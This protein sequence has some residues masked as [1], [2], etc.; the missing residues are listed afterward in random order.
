MAPLR[1][2]SFPDLASE[3]AS[4]NADI[5]P[6]S[7][8]P[9]G[10]GEG[11]RPDRQLNAGNLVATGMVI[12]LI[13]AVAYSIGYAIYSLLG[14]LAGHQIL[15]GPPV[16]LRLLGAA[17]VFI[18]AVV[19]ADVFRFRRPWE[20]WVSTSVTFMKLIGRLPLSEPLARTEPFVPRGPYVYVRS[21]MYFGV[22]AISVGLGLAVASLPLLFWGLILACWY[23]FFLIPFE[24]RELAALFGASYEDYRRRVP[25]L[26]P[27]GRKYKQTGER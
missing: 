24:E 10:K 21:P 27:Y 7:Y 12:L 6:R 14:L 18:G 16:G 2:E 22:V 13:L 4:P 25:K 9:R 15:F 11:M 19:A 3:N 1:A 8:R 20:V 5:S 26:F 17:L 23:W